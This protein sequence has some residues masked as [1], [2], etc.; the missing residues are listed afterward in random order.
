MDFSQSDSGLS[1]RDF[2]LLLGSLG[3]VA[4]PTTVL[5]EE[6]KKL[7]STQELEAAIELLCRQKLGKILNDDQ[8][9]RVHRAV[10]SRRQS[11]EALKKTPVKNSDD[12]AEAFRADF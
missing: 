12:P 2:A 7:P 10:L 1:R 6:E 4:I 8:L 11:A 5:A 3:A 9:K